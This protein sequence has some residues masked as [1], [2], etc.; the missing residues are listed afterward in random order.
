[1]TATKKFCDENVNNEKFLNDAARWK[2]E[3]AGNDWICSSKFGS[4]E[5]AVVVD[6]GGLPVFDRPL[7][8]EAPNVNCV[9]WGR[10]KDGVAK[11]AVLRQPRPH[12]DDPENPGNNHEPVVFGQIVMGFLER[13]IGKDLTERYESVEGGASRE[14][15]EEAGVN[16]VLNIERP[17]YPWHNPNP[18][19]VATWSDLVF[20][21]VDLEQISLLKQDRNEP[22]F[23]AEYIT[24]G[25]LRQRIMLGK[26]GESAVY[27]M[28]TANSAWFIF[29][30]C[31]PELF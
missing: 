8:R 30:C 22:I 18:T 17:N 21:E 27:R 1:M 23:S 15:S 10:D 16:V 4:V 3:V 5:T 25:E 6:A 13:I 31:Y 29:F 9:V 7:Y 19:F 24:A 11:F 12:S 14:A 20:V 26:D 2:L 28:C